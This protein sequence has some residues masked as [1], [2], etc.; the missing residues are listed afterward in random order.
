MSSSRYIS[1]KPIPISEV[2]TH[3]QLI[4]QGVAIK[5][6]QTLWIKVKRAKNMQ[7]KGTLSVEDIHSGKKIVE[8][9]KSILSHNKL[10]LENKEVLDDFEN[11][12]I[13][14]KTL[15]YWAFDKTSKVPDWE[16]LTANVITKFLK[17]DFKNKNVNDILVNLGI[18]VEE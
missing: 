16:T 11:F 15:K 7:R 12:I 5:D 8:N 14:D 13:K 17:D 6:K 1:G 18:L 2:P 3:K 9:N 10:P 4:K